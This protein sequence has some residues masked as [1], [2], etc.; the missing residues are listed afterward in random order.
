MSS[1]VFVHENY[2]AQMRA[3]TRLLFLVEVFKNGIKFFP[4]IV[5]L[6]IGIVV[7]GPWRSGSLSVEASTVFAA[8]TIMIRVFLSLGA[9]MTSGGALLIDSRAAKDLGT[10]I[11]IDRSAHEPR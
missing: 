5:A 10:L 7:L 3:Y 6:S 1:E 2:A 4:G 11:S 9:L 8:T